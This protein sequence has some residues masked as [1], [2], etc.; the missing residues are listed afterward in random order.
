MR[1]KTLEP[2]Y[3][4]VSLAPGFKEVVITLSGLLL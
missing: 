1:K 3:R 4:F 2:F